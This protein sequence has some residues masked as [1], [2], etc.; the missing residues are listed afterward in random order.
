MPSVNLSS[1]RSRGSAGESAA[2][3]GDYLPMLPS[4][5]VGVRK[6][7]L[8]SPLPH[9]RL[10]TGD[11]LLLYCFCSCFCFCLLLLLFLPLAI[12]HMPQVKIAKQFS[13]RRGWDLNP[14]YCHQ[15]TCF[16][17]TP[18]KPYLGTSPAVS[19]YNAILLETDYKVKRQILAI[20]ISHTPSV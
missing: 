15:Y 9:S 3:K 16:P 14:R 13:W 2:H 5:P 11:K 10:R 6:P 8:R 20:R 7:L 19:L 12:S 17:G 18:L 1:E 4:G